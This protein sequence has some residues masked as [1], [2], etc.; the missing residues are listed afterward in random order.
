MF[1]T[2]ATG[3]HDQEFTVA[4]IVLLILVLDWLAMLAETILR[5]SG[6]ALQVFAVVLGVTQAA[7]GLQVILHNLRLIGVF[8]GGAS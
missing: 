8:A 6:T 2:I 3:R 7:L 1:A 4:G 5:W